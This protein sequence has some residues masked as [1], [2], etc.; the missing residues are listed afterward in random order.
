[1][2]HVVAFPRAPLTDVTR[3]PQISAGTD[4]NFWLGIGEYFTLETW[5]FSGAFEMRSGDHAVQE[6]ASVG[7]TDVFE[8]VTPMRGWPQ[9]VSFAAGAVSREE[10]LGTTYEQTS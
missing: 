5:R 7:A 9:P 6:I 4:A 8:P 10:L 1:M 2:T 3:H